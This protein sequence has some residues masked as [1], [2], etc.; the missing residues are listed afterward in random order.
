M[1]S[2]LI[3]YDLHTPGRDY[4][5]LHAAIKACG[6]WWHYL[7]STWIVTTSRYTTANDLF[8]YLQPHVG[9]ADRLLILAIR[10]GVDRE[11]WL[12]KDAWDWLKANLIQ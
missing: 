5:G 11:G 12:P 10:A 4:A 3:T 9:K 8:V 6:G 7:E 2:F 1:W